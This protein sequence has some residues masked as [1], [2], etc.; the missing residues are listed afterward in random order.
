[1][2]KP[3]LAFIGGTGAEGRGLATRFAGAGHPVR[4]GSR[5][6]VRAEQTASVL[7]AA[8]PEGAD[9]R[10]C[11]NTDAVAAAEIAIL[12]IPYEAQQAT[13][14]S[15]R[16]ALTGKIVITAVV[17]MEFRDGQARAIV[18]PEG[19]A[20][21]QAQALLPQSRVIGAF[22]HVSARKLAK[23]DVAVGGDCLVFG[24]DAEAKAT[25]IA[26]VEEI[27]GLRPVDAGGLAAAYPIE[28]FTAALVSINRVHRL[29]TGVRIAGLRDATP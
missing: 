9:V 14:E 26:L 4:I 23:P 25:V 6:A 3:T 19:S 11:S 24:D 22:H 7:R 18:V 2:S 17:P 1:M 16:D 13:L 21:E 27:E 5:D 20:A 28:I 8:L 29:E 10:G 12:A 15:L